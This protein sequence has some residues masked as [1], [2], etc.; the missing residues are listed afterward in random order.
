M[1]GAATAPL[2]GTVDNIAAE[3]ESRHPR[4]AGARRGR[5][6]GRSA[7]EADVRARAIQSRQRRAAGCWSRSS[8]ILRDDENLPFVYVAQPD[9]SFARRQVTLGDRTGDQYEITAGLS[10]GDQIVVDGGIFLQ[11]MQNQ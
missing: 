6:P 11:F 8:A 7:E 1:T 4:G 2:P 5:Q 10:A 3:V 9:G